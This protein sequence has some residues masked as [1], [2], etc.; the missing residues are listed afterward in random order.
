MENKM[1]LVVAE[2]W[3]WLGKT[4]LEIKMAQV[5]TETRDCLTKA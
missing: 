3:E 1:V 2:T 5:V 4:R